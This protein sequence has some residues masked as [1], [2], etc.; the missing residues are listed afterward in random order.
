MKTT[1][2]VLVFAL[3]AIFAGSASANLSGPSASGVYH[4]VLEDDLPKAVEFEAQTDERGV[5]TGSLTV[6]GEA[7][8]SDWEP[9]E[10]PGHP[11]VVEFS[12]TADLDTLAIEHNRAL[13]GGTVR[14]STNRNYVGKWIQLVVEDSTDEREPDKVSWCLCQPEAT[15]WVPSDAEVPGDEGA[16]WKWWA[17]DAEL[18]EDVGIPSVNII[19]GNKTSCDKFPLGAYEFAEMKSG[20]GQIQ[21]IP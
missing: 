13:M 3:T 2:F 7:V 5:T 11:E 18:R 19:P 20:E 12:I 17:T 10:E 8:F 15:G 14:E 6:S 9:D 16:W 4:F 1:A 21:V